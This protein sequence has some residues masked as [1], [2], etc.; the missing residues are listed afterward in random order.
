MNDGLLREIF[1]LDDF[2]PQVNTVLVVSKMVEQDLKKGLAF[3]ERDC[4]TMSSNTSQS[5]DS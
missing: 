2:L 4:I 1:D 5:A 3:E